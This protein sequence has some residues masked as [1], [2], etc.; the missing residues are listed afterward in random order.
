MD[1]LA[2]ITF[3]ST[4]KRSQRHPSDRLRQALRDYVQFACS[5]WFSDGFT[6]SAHDESRPQSLPSFQWTFMFASLPFAIIG[7]DFIQHFVLLVDS[8]RHRHLDD[9][10]KL[11]FKC[12]LT[13]A[14][15]LSPVFRIADVSPAYA[16][17]LPEYLWLVR[18]AAE[19]PP[20]T[21]EVAEHIVTRIL[22]VIPQPGRLA[23]DKLGAAQ[24]ECDHMLQLGTLRSSKSS[25]ASP[26]HMDAK[27]VMG[28]GVLAK[29]IEL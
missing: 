9:R 7:I 3:S 10:A 16:N 19:L 25:W 22:P 23:P 18:P 17:L 2:F 13:E 28:T 26:L 5:Q 6:R 14:P 1:R 11:G 20:V 15:I 27:K 4:R 24:A 21:T 8:G 12:I 29:T